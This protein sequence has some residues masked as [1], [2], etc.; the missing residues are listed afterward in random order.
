MSRPRFRWIITVTRDRVLQRCQ[1]VLPGW[2]DLTVADVEF[3]FVNW[4][5]RADDEMGGGLADQRQANAP[6]LRSSLHD[7][8]VRERHVR[9]RAPARYQLAAMTGAVSSL[10]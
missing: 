8:P 2:S 4:S 3:Y 5:S 1:S 7:G 6:Y 9:A 10:R